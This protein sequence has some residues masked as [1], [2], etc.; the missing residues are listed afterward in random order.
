[1]VVK[2]VVWW[3]VVVAVA[4]AVV[5][6]D[7]PEEYPVPAPEPTP[8]QP[9]PEPQPDPDPT[10]NGWSELPEIITSATTSVG[11]HF[12]TLGSVERRNYTLLYDTAERVA[13]WV[14]YPLHSLY[15]GSVGRTDAWAYDP[16][17]GQNE[18]MP[19]VNGS[20][21]VKGFDRGHQIP[22]ADRQAS[23][24]ANAQTFYATNMTPQNSTLNQGEWAKLEGWVRDRAADSKAGGRSDTLYVVTGCVLTTAESPT[25]ER[26]TKSGVS[27]AVPKA[28]YKVL[29]R[30]R[31][32]DATVPEGAD[33]ECIGFWVENRAPSDGFE[34]WAVSVATIEALSGQTFFP[35]IDPTLKQTFN[36][37]D[38]AL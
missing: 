7:P 3:L 18:Q 38:W 13:L 4:V 33:A 12:V 11:T 1:V 23:Y 37:T 16:L 19:I 31:S 15:L 34:A 17:F 10:G 35:Q 30:T 14:A 21:G 24:T 26:L 8:V 20:Y 25:V 22:S 9:K 5:G 32:G 29:V 6:C 2:K 36:T 28:Y 27:G